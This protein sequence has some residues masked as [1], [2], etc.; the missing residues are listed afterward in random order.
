[1]SHS[2]QTDFGFPG[3]D[4]NLDRGLRGHE[5]RIER[6]WLRFEA[7]FNFAA[8]THLLFNHNQTTLESI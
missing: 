5:V 4:L 7:S 3:S 8:E 2:C 6:D 1:M